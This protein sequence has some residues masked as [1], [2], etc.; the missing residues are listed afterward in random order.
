MNRSKLPTR[1]NLESVK[2]SFTHN[3]NWNRNAK[4]TDFQ[5]IRKFF[6]VV[7]KHFESSFGMKFEPNLLFNLFCQVSLTLAC[8]MSKP[9]LITFHIKELFQSKQESRHKFPFQKSS[10]E[11]KKLSCFSLTRLPN[12]LFLAWEKRKFQKKR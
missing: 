4:S 3:T 8:A 10:E 11:K 5:N 9:F 1:L 6:H 12:Q 7:F 2:T